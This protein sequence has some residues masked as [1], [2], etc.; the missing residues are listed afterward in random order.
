VRI[1]ETIS[2]ALL[3]FL[4]AFVTGVLFFFA[5]DSHKWLGAIG[6]WNI[7]IGSFISVFLA[8]GILWRSYKRQKV[9]DHD[10]GNYVPNV[11]AQLREDLEAGHTVVGTM[12]REITTL[13]RIDRPLELAK[14]ETTVT[15]VALKGNPLATIGA[16]NGFL[17]R[18]WDI[19]STHI[20]PPMT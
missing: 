20:G 19:A 14:I 5:L 1:G 13:R 7:L 15:T 12:F 2:S 16:L 10:L 8:L 18:G 17:V 9:N 11:T 4:C 6:E 3:F